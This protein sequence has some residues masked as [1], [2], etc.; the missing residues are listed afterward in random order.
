M[1]QPLKMQ[2]SY[3]L[4]PGADVGQIRLRYNAPVEIE[5]GGSLRIG[6]ETGQIRESSPVAW[7]YFNGRRIPVEVTFCLLDS[8]ICNPAWVLPWDNITPPT[9]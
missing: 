9:R 2:S 7:Q 6:Y 4:A 1:E 8:P 5:A 3:L